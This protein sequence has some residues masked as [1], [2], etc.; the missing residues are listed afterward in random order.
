MNEEPISMPTSEPE[1]IAESRPQMMEAPLL[2]KNAQ[3]LAQDKIL[4]DA[5]TKAKTTLV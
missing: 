1:P 4:H 2:H 3:H 5:A